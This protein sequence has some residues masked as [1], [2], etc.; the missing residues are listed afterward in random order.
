MPYQGLAAPQYNRLRKRLPPAVLKVLNE[1]Q[2]QILSNPRKGDRK[3]GELRGVWVEKFTVEN[4]KWLLGYMIGVK[5]KVI[6]FLPVGRHENFYR[7]ITRYLRS[8]GRLSIR[9]PGSSS[10]PAIGSAHPRAR[11][12]TKRE[13]SEQEY[14]VQLAAPPPVLRVRRPR[15]TGGEDR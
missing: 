14:A 1:V 10:T 13:T 11:V 9:V 2:A 8:W 5:K 6:F 4:D 3:S 7:D 15:L 12:L